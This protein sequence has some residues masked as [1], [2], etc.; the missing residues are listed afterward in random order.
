MDEKKIVLAIEKLTAIEE[1]AKDLREYLATLTIPTPIVESVPV[2]EEIVVL[3][4]SAETGADDLKQIIEEYGLNELSVE[5]IKEYLNSATPPIEYNKKAKKAEVLVPILAEAILD[6]LIPLEDDEEEVVAEETAEEE[7]AEDDDELTVKDIEEMPLKELLALAKDNDLE[8]PTKIKKDETAVRNL[9][10]ETFFLEEEEEDE[11]EEIEEDE[12]EDAV[13]ISDERKAEEA[14]I[15]D[16]IESLYS[17][18][19]LTIKHMKDFLK[20]Y[21]D[22]KAECKDCKGCKENE[23]VACY[24]QL[25]Q[26]FVDDYGEVLEEA[27]AYERDGEVY[28]CGNPCEADPDDDSAVVCTICGEQWDL[29]E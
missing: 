3:D 17:A 24:I 15:K 26:N 28:C 5:E 29:S 19:K 7:V 16:E 11:V 27:Q 2:K 25:K 12:V 10:I 23:I 20:K 22:G 4:K 9:I 13:N 21:Y 6:G 14:K 8:I 18:K 1:F